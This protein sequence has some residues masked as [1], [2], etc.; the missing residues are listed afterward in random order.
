MQYRLWCY[1]DSAGSTVSV[2]AKGYVCSVL[3]NDITIGIKIFTTSDLQCIDITVLLQILCNKLLYDV[4]T[5][6]HD[7][8]IS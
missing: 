7:I 2:L 3:I 5:Q 8:T 6:M 1:L 4:A